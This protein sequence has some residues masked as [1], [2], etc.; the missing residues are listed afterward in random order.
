M[1]L[2][3]WVAALIEAAIGNFPDMS[4]LIFINI[5]NASIGYYEITKAGD[6]VAALKASLKNEATV[7]RNGRF[8]NIK[9]DLLVPGDLISLELGGAVPADAVINEGE[10]E[11]NQSA[12]TGESLPVNMKR[13]MTVK[14]GSTVEK[15]H[16]EATV[17]YT[18]K[19][20]E[21]GKTAAML[22]QTIEVSNLQLILIK[23]VV[24]LTLASLV[25]CS[26]V[27]GYITALSTFTEGLSFAVVLMVASIPMAIEIVTTT[28]LALGSKELSHDGAIVTR[29]AAIEDLA[30]M[31]ILCSDKTGTLTLNKMVLQ[32]ETPIYLKGETQYSVLRY[33][34]MAAR[35]KDPPKDALDTLVFNAVDMKSLENVEQKDFMPFDP[36]VKRTEGTVVENGATYKTT[37]G[38]PH[39]LLKLCNNKAV[40]EQVE[41]DVTA[42]GERGIR[43]LAVAKTNA[44]GEWEMIAILSFLDPPR[45]DTKDT[46]ARARQYGV[47]VKMITGDHLLIAK[48]TSK[49]LDLGEYICGPQNLPMLVNGEAPRGLA[50]DYGDLC[51]AADGFAQVF[52]E[53][54]MLI[55]RTIRE[56]GYKC[57]MTGDGVNDA[58]AL[59]EADVG[60]AVKG[61]TAAAAA[62]ADIVL[63]EEGLSTIVLGIVIARRIFIRIHNF[64]TYR[65]AATVQLLVFFFIAVLCFKPSAYMPS[66]WETNP[67]FQGDME[68]PDFFHMPVLMLMLI[69]LL[70]DVSL[71]AIGYDNAI[72]RELPE[73]W[74]LYSLFTVAS[75]LAGVAL[76]SSL[77]L[78]H[79]LLTSWNSGGMQI[80]Y[81]QLITSIYLKVSIS[82]F[83]TLFSCRTGEHYFWATMPSKYLLFAG[84]FSMTLSTILALCWPESTVDGVYTQGLAYRP[85]KALV[86]Y[87]WLYC[88]AWFFVQDV[89]KVFTYHC[90]KV[91]NIFKYNETGKL[92]LPQSTVNY[93]ARNKEAHMNAKAAHH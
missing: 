26:V 9:A 64:I 11:V 53:H 74:N 37:K 5:A 47:A 60:I 68:W 15:G 1:P 76:I 25:L 59:R 66:G 92:I 43:S 72:P 55:V 54:K 71:I 51:L 34:A 24:V 88:I 83:L 45:P 18:G 49:Q 20:T 48:E 28:T 19:Y 22:K 85:P 56:L 41:K 90:M 40:I 38:A 36:T 87:I 65:I 3:I 10:L 63:T 2:M 52:P 12:L 8:Y 58:P 29:L 7:K 16:V 33:A 23:I 91:Y 46:I 17:R 81:G 21:F 30:G 31:S 84:G 61:A 89:A 39:V 32:E 6:A 79:V 86:V 42:F 78:L 50:R 67:D 69:T 27:L 82:D 62:A 44:K 35:W 93:I 4:I 73:K 13:G 57:G 75:V 14:M 70:N 80:S 77:I